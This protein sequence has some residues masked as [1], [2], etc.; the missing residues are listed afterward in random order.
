MKLGWFINAT[1]P[2]ALL[3]RL[4]R[5]YELSRRHKDKYLTHPL[6]ARALEW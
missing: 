3:T 1:S 2:M 6:R 5:A 4:G